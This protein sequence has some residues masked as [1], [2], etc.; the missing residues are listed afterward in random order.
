MAVSVQ[1]LLF[2]KM[3]HF[4][5]VFFS[6]VVLMQGVKTVTHGPGCFFL[7]HQSNRR[8]FLHNVQDHG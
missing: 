4:P 7:V 1:R 6:Q 5:V 3:H 8:N 2:L